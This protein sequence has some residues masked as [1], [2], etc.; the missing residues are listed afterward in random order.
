VGSVHATDGGAVVEGWGTWVID[1]E[2]WIDRQ[3]IA[4]SE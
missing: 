1:V 2:F 3:V 4:S